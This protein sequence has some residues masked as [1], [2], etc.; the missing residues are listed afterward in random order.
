MTRRSLKDLRLG[1][2]PTTTIFGG[3]PAVAL[4]DSSMSNEEF[5]RHMTKVFADVGSGRRLILG[6]SDNVPVDAN[7]DRLERITEMVRAFGPVV[8]PTD[9]SL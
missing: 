1:M 9:G 8:P 4:L 6:V 3:I 7:L 5:E 2:G